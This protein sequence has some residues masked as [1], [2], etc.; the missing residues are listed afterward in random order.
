MIRSK[1]KRETSIRGSLFYQLRFGPCENPRSKDCF[2]REGDDLRFTQATLLLDN[3]ITILVE[4][5]II[6]GLYCGDLNERYVLYLLWPDGKE[7]EDGNAINLPDFSYGRIYRKAGGM[8]RY[9]NKVAKQAELPVAL[10]TLDF[11]NQY[12]ATKTG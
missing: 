5:T 12:V 8:S 10:G 3:G 6:S 4:N 1:C 2:R 7:V 9:M 11:N